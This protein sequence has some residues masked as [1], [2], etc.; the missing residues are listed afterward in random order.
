MGREIGDELLRQGS[1]TVL[2][3][4]LSRALHVALASLAGLRVRIV[5]ASHEAALDANLAVMVQRHDRS[6]QRQIGWPENFAVTHFRSGTNIIGTVP[7]WAMVPSAADRSVARPGSG[8]VSR[9]VGSMIGTTAH[10]VQTSVCTGGG[11]PSGFT[12]CR[13]EC[14]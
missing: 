2:F 10:T 8:A 14:G 3:I 7:A 9:C 11:T 1:A 6:G 5:L 13:G 4:L 12:R